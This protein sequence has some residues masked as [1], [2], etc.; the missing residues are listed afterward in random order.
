MIPQEDRFKSAAPWSLRERVTPLRTYSGRVVYDRPRHFFVIKD[1]D[2]I[3]KAL[4]TNPDP[5]SSPKTVWDLLVKI[6]E[7]V[8]KIIDMT[9]LDWLK[10]LIGP[11]W[12]MMW[13]TKG[14]IDR[15]MDGQSLTD[16]EI[17]G[18]VRQMFRDT[19]ALLT[20]DEEDKEIRAMG[21]IKRG[22]E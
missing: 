14:L 20:S 13:R 21:W 5:K 2:R 1:I 8:K 17:R 16:Q 3:L 7:F 6:F 11:L 15:I 10:V 18:N 4:E 22:D 12:N 19:W 9:A